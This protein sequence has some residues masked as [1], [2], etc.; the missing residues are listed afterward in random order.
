VGRAGHAGARDGGRSAVPSGAVALNLV[1]PGRSAVPSERAGRRPRRPRLTGII[2]SSY[3]WPAVFSPPPRQDH[4]SRDYLHAQVSSIRGRHVI[5]MASIGLLRRSVESHPNRHT[6]AS[7]TL[8]ALAC[9]VHCDRLRR[10]DGL[11][12]AG[13]I[14]SS[15][16]WWTR[17]T[18]LFYTPQLMRTGR[19]VIAPNGRC[20]IAT[21]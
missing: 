10:S 20:A 8:L 11:Q 16:G 7:E 21:C 12:N 4:G 1:L 5:D 18:P 17:R 3:P 6:A 14:P 19:P 2:A 13:A 15:A 9:G